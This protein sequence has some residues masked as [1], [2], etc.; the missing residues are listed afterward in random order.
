MYLGSFLQIPLAF[1]S[2]NPNIYKLWYDK[3]FPKQKN[4]S[5]VN[6]LFFLTNWGLLEAFNKSKLTEHS[7]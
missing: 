5:I 1:G 3:L 6:Q 2:V 4:Q 7:I